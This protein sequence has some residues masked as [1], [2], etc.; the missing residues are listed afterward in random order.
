MGQK[1]ARDTTASAPP[2]SKRA[3]QSGTRVKAILQRSEPHLRAPST[4]PPPPFET[5]AEVPG[6]EWWLGAH[7]ALAADLL[8]LPLVADL[9][10][11]PPL[12]ESGPEAHEAHAMAVRQLSQLCDAV[13]DALYEL[14]CDAADPR[15]AELSGLLAALEPPVRDT[16]AWCA[17]VVAFLTW[18]AGELRS[19]T[20][21]D[22]SAA[23]V[24]Y[25]E[26]AAKRPQADDRPRA[27]VASSPIDF[28]SPVEPLRNLLA[29]L[30][31]LA[32]AISA[33]DEALSKR[34]A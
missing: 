23:K 14:Y 22:W 16:Y 11:L 18:I 7:M 19:E 5:E 20:G 3:P 9:L 4:L 13:R 25:R 10:C 12:V 34:F 33:L 26:L 15:A 8:C 28:A 21:L 29:N 27:L 17:S 31:N 2:E 1:K 24:R 6:L 32:A 30:D